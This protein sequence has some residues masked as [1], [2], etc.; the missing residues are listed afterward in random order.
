MRTR[1]NGTVRSKVKINRKRKGLKG[2][3]LGAH[4]WAVKFE[5]LPF[6]DVMLRRV[7]CVMLHVRNSGWNR[8]QFQFHRETSARQSENKKQK[9]ERKGNKKTKTK[10]KVKTK[11]RRTFITSYSS[12][13]FVVVH[14]RIN[15]NESA[16]ADSDLYC[17]I[18]WNA[19]SHR[20]YLKIRRNCVLLVSSDSV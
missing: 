14:L 3:E 15:T 20:R 18:Y 6:S 4:R 2:K 9:E 5:N 10:V 17:F 16:L 1:P 13:P 19:H 7:L 12:L 11:N 8:F